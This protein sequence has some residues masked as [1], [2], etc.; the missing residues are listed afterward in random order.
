MNALLAPLG[1]TTAN[2]WPL[3]LIIAIILAVSMPYVYFNLPNDNAPENEIP[4]P[5]DKGMD[6]NT[7]RKI[8]GQEADMA[9]LKVIGAIRD[10]SNNILGALQGMARN[11]QCP[12]NI[13]EELIDQ[14]LK[15]LRESFRRYVKKAFGNQGAVGQVADSLPTEELDQIQ[16]ELKEL[17]ESFQDLTKCVGLAIQSAVDTATE[18]R[19]NEAAAFKEEISKGMLKK[20][21]T[22]LAAIELLPEEKRG[23]PLDDLDESLKEIGISVEMTQDEK[24][25]KPVKDGEEDGGVKSE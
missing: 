19:R 25:S 21:R 5:I 9:F 20:M 3:L 18:E 6:E 17:K 15:N 1:L 22:L 4:K 7:L 14:K 16:K 23:T 10:E 24:S 13:T 11:N 8:F 12:A 2:D